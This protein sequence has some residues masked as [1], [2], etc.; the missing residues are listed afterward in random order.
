M[1]TTLVATVI[2]LVPS[3]SCST[4]TRSPG[5]ELPT[6]TVPKPSCSSSATSAVVS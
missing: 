1:F 3:S 5:G 6:Q 2:R 4:A